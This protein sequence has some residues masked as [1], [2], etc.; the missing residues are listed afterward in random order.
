MENISV[1]GYVIL[2]I[3]VLI[4]AGVVYA[5]FAYKRMEK[6]KKNLHE[7]LQ[8]LSESFES[9]WKNQ[10]Q[11]EAEAEAEAINAQIKSDLA[12][13]LTRTLPKIKC[14][15]RNVFIFFTDHSTTKKF[16]SNMFPMIRTVYYDYRHG[17]SMENLKSKFFQ[18]TKKYVLVELEKQKKTL[19]FWK[20]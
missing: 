17:V 2:G 15:P 18:E 16:T 7:I 4:G 6:S 1:H 14:F 11:Q 9:A 10:G 20:R 13:K 19:T 8:T 3:F 12:D 5:I